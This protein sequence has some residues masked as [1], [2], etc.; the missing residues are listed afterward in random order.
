M[1]IAEAVQEKPALLGEL[2]KS[3]I[4][5]DAR[6]SDEQPAELLQ[7]KR[8]VFSGAD[9]LLHAGNLLVL[10]GGARLRGEDNHQRIGQ[11]GGFGWHS[12]ATRRF[13]SAGNGQQRGAK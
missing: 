5:T 10:G 8:L 4:E 6:L 7:R 3:G 9:L 1:A 2:V 11:L 12:R 13:G